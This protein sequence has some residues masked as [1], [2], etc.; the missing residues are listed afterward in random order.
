[1]TMKEDVQIRSARL[2]DCADIARL[3]LISS[4][5]LAEYIWSR[6]DLPGLSTIE[7]GARRYAREGTTFSYENCL[8]ADR[9]GDVLGMVHGFPMEAQSADSDDSPD[10]VLAPYAELEDIGSFY[11][12][13]VALYPQYRGLGI[14]TR[15]LD[16]ARD[17]ARALGLERLSLICFERNQ[18]ATRLYL[19]LGYVEID[20]RAI[21]SHP[22]LRYRDGDAVLLVRPLDRPGA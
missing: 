4:E 8:V 13:G 20:R 2:E 7:I 15:L 19:R 14:G 10:P 6:I 21:V 17:R 11:L 12:S 3:F 18:Q 9:A 1:G 22:A 5:G 16:A